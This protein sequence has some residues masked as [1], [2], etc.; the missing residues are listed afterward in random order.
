MKKIIFFIILVLA[1]AFSFVCTFAAPMINTRLY[2][3][4]A[5]HN[6]SAEEV[7]I[8][9][10]GETLTQ[11][12]MFPIILNSRILVPARDVFEKMGCEVLWNEAQRQV[13]VKK[14]SDVVLINIDSDT[15]Y[16]NNSSFKID[17]AAK[18]INERTMIPLRAVSEAVGCEVEWNNSSRTAVITYNNSEAEQPIVQPSASEQPTVQPAVQPSS[19]EQTTDSSDK[20]E[21]GI[22]ILWDQ[23]TNLDANNAEGKRNTVNGLNVISPTW[24]SIKNSEGD[25]ND[26]ASAEYVQWAHSNG[27]QV[28][29]LVSN[30]FDSELTHNVLSDQNKRLKV[31]N[32]LSELADKYD[33]DGINVD[34]ESVNINDGDYYLAFI[35]EIT[36]ALKAKIL[37]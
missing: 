19:Q 24:F 28:W 22:K 13:S 32:Q 36:Q 9:I 11:Y 1:A 20:K 23:I 10:N 21:G 12:T 25:I 34:F 8:S 15:A 30:S 4:G 37:L 16:K 35:K 31:I 29:G 27:Y 6:Y 5:L 17:S 14:G 33:L 7:K 26:I 18:I 2:Y 3:D